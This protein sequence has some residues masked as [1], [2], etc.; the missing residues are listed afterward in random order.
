[1]PTVIAVMDLGFLL[2]PQ[3]FTAKDFHQ[4]KSWTAY[5]VRQATKIIAISEN[6]KRDII[7][8]FGKAPADITVTYLAHDQKLFRPTQNQ[9]VLDKY[10]IKQPYIL[11][12]SSLKPSKNVEGLVKAFSRLPTADYRLVIAGKKAWKYETI[13][14]LVQELKLQDR[15]IFTDYVPAADSP[16]LMSMAEAFVLPSFYEGFA[17]PALE[18]MA[19]G[20]PVVVSKVANLPEVVGQAVVYI[21]PH[22]IDSICTGIQTALAHR[23]RL[24]KLGLTQAKQ[25]S[26]AATA[27]QTM[28]VLK[29]AVKIT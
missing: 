14:S 26:W 21:D 24:I 19:C 4:L 3:Q 22:H 16:V 28:S 8:F 1:M 2:F 11:S 27:K 13:F 25:F 12:L 9:P 6:T 18:A 20:T 17:L 10:G 15:V 29:S 5:S 7:K 23:S